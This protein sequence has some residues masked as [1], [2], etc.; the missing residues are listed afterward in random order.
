MGQEAVCTAHLDGEAT[1]GKALL[2]TDEVIFRGGFRT[3]VPFREIDAVEVDGDELVL[4]FGRRTLILGLGARVATTWADKIRNPKSRLDK[5]GVTPGMRVA[6][7]GTLDDDAFRKELADRVDTV[8]VR[9]RRGSDI[10]FFAAHRTKDLDR[11]A[12]FARSLAP[13]GAIWVIRPKGVATISEQDVLARGRAAG[14]V[15]TKVVRFSDTHTAEKFVIPV[16]RRPG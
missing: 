8:A 12:T 15:D 3:R 1:D 10:I 14:L 6:I 2:E 9:P 5:L 7:V 4:R 11:L 13:T 16:A